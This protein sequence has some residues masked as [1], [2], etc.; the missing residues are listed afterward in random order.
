MLAYP[1]VYS[2][3]VL[4]LSVVR[5]VGF[6]QERNHG[7][8]NIPS[9]ATLAVCAIYGLSGACNVILLLTT[10]PS[11][12]LF[13][14]PIDYGVTQ[15]SPSPGLLGYTDDQSSVNMQTVTSRP[16]VHSD[17]LQLGRL[18]SR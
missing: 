12:V 5:W 8:N 3:T 16:V 17:G 13:G 4:P 18:P 14:R 10:R 2:I 11:S 7:H 6:V 1:I 9:A 15:R